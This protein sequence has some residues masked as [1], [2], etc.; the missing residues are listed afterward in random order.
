MTG[1]VYCIK[2]IASGQVIYVGSTTMLLSKR[3]KEHVRDCFTRV[4]QRPLY[5]YIRSKATKETFNNLF[6]FD[7]LYSGEFDTR[8]ELLIK[9]REYMEKFNPK[10]NVNKPFRSKDE[11][12]QQIHEWY[13]QHK[14]E[15]DIRLN[16]LLNKSKDYYAKHKEDIKERM[17]RYYAEHK[18]ERKAYSKKYYENK[19][20]Q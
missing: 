16:N 12:K 20:Q 4:K 11:K 9:E 17:K 3:V 18:E 5:K 8:Q 10:L 1:I 7:V 14:D 13:L 6:A 2:E 19:C 15:E